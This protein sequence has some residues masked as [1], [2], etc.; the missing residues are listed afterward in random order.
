[1]S[2]QPY[3]TFSDEQLIKV[4]NAAVYLTQRLGPLSKTKL[5]KLFYILDELAIK[6]SGIPFLNLTYKVWKFGP[7][8]EELFIDLSSDLKLLA[9]YLGKE[10]QEGD[11]YLKPL[12]DFD[13]AEFSENDI[14]L[15][16][17]VVER[18]GQKTAKDLVAYT[19]RENSPWH[20]QAKAQN[21][22][23]LLESEQINNTEFAIDMSQLVVHDP[24]KLALYIAF[25][26]QH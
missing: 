17:D 15:M 16:D 4:G 11:T 19:H 23:H 13:D 20:T 6:K 24:R 7:V 5:L 1:M 3:I 25:K 10:I 2:A 18:F 8:S 9:G 26:E 14:A 21:V 22:L 12:A